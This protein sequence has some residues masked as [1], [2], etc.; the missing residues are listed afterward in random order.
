MLEVVALLQF[1]NIWLGWLLK[2]IDMYMQKSVLK[3]AIQ[4][5][6]VINSVNFQTDIVF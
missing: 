3:F 6:S 2:F 1:D 5:F 4:L